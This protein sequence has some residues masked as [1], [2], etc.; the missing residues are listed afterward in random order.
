M[1]RRSLTTL[2]A[3]GG[4]AA[5]LALL[6]TSA[7][8]APYSGGNYG[9]Y[10]MEGQYP[11]TSFCTGT[12][13]QVGATKY[14]EGMALK[15]FYSDKCGSFARIENSRANCA[16]VLQRSNGGVGR[17][18]GWVSETVDPG[19]TYAYTQMGNNLNG[20]VSRAVLSCDGHDLV[21]T[22]WY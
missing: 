2:L 9:A 17:V 22:G 18:D 6:P 3:A 19:I 20:R 21:A 14:A 12:F 4:A 16:A 11:T 10:G 8:A 13:R 7:Q 15:Y 1:S 5:V